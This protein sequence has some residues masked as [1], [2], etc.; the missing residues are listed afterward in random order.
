MKRKL[1]LLAILAFMLALFLCA[2]DPTE[3]KPPDGTDDD[4]WSVI[5]S[6]SMNDIYTKFLGGFTSIA[7][8]FS[9]TKLNTSPKVSLDSKLK[10]G[11]NGNDFWATMKLNYNNNEKQNLMFA[12]ELTSKEDSYEDLVLGLFVY[13]EQMYVAFGQTKFSLS[14]N[15]KAWESFFPFDYN[16]NTSV[17]NAAMLLGSTLVNSVNPVGKFR[18]NGTNEEYNYVF[19][20]DVPQSL[21]KLF[22]YMQNNQESVDEKTMSD[23]EKIISGLFGVTVQDIVDGKFP[24][25]TIKLDFT[26]SNRKISALDASLKIEDIK[27]GEDTLL[28]GSKL[29]LDVKLDTF[30]ISKQNVGIPFVNSEYAAERTKYVD[31]IDNAFRVKLNS[32]K[33]IDSNTVNEYEV[34]VTAKVFQEDSLD[35]YAFVEYKNK[36]TNVIDTALYIYKNVAYL[37]ETVGGEFVCKLSMPLDLSDVSTKTIENDFGTNSKIDWISAIGYLLRSIRIGSDAIT[38]KHGSGFFEHVWFNVYDMLAYVNSHFEEDILEITEVKNFVEFVTKKA[39]VITFEYDIPFLLL[40]PD[41]DEDL[42]IAIERLLSA[43]PEI[44]LTEKVTELIPE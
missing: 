1:T 6:P 7:T 13:Q 14:F 39:A 11:V 22:K 2:C 15:S 23:F 24:E 17:S 20:L 44:V 12:F 27:N 3:K 18:M 35:N 37:Y 29:A 33:Q 25:S 16:T 40:V 21:S 36:K 30:A 32:T 43:E 34:D 28:A 38:L 5:D 41:N 10:V 19:T 8:E 31:Y 9:R 26:T 4:G 42:A